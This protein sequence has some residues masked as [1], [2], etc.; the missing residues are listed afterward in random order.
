MT[1][2]AL[3]GCGRMGMTHAGILARLEETSLVRVYD[4]DGAA[5]AAAAKRHGAAAAASPA[6]AVEAGDVDAV[7]VASATP[8]HAGFIEL[9]VRA[10]KPVLCEKPIDLDVAR[11][12]AC[13]EVVVAHPDVP[14]QIGFNRRFDPGHAAA[15]AALAAGEIGELLHA[16]ITSRD[17]GMPPRAYC[18]AAGGLLR[19]MTIHDFDM[20]RCCLGEEP[21]EV[22]AVAGRLC[23]PRLMEEI[24][25]HDS[26]MVILRTAS[27]RLCHINN[28]RAAAYGYDQRVELHG[29]RGMVISDNDREHGLA[30]YA[31]DAAAGGAPLRRF[32]IDRYLRSYELEILAFVDAVRTGRPPVPGF[33]DG[34]RALQL[35]DAA[36]R[37]VAS[38][39]IEAI[40]A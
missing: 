11:V 19:D 28:T 32:F 37:S 16:V 38:G 26:A 3:L 24:D 15:L 27:G 29:D 5:A 10:G 30:K 4:I 20:A 40:E 34:L 17:P 31:K 8:T 33:H 25:D 7:L 6:A 1:R 9:A 21:V 36:Y 14:V 18:E 39:R 35:A 13:Q 23:D 2:F 22:F 12:R